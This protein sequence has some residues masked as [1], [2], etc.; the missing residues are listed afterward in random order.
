MRKRLPRLT[1]RKLFLSAAHMPWHSEQARNKRSGDDDFIGG[2]RG[3]V[4]PECW[5][6]QRLGRLSRRL[7]TARFLHSTT[8]MCFKEQR[9][10]NARKLHQVLRSFL[11]KLRAHQNPKLMEQTLH[12]R[13]GEGRLAADL[14]SDPAMEVCSALPALPMLPHW[15][16]A[17]QHLPGAAA[18]RSFCET[19][20]NRNYRSPPH[21]IT[22]CELI[23]FLNEFSCYFSNFSII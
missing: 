18:G 12:A 20:G 1:K 3:E 23:L 7:G 8:V 9:L 15:S 2:N 5:A 16:G 10:E 19:R 22:L 21:T 6:G 11:R 4:C 13:L 14:G 17:L